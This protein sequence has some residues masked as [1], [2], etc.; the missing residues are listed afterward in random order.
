[1]EK[2]TPQFELP[3]RVGSANTR[4]LFRNVA[5]AMKSL[6]KDYLTLQIVMDKFKYE[7]AVLLLGV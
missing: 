5:T 1:M 3:E 6:S 4:E 2:H 7:A